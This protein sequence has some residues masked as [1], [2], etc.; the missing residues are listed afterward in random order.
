M[1]ASLSFGLFGL[2][3]MRVL[4]QRCSGLKRLTFLIVRVTALPQRTDLGLKLMPKPKWLC[5]TRRTT[6]NRI[7]FTSRIRTLRSSLR[8]IIRSRGLLLLSLCSVA[9]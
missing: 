8:Y 6:L 2:S 4:V 5:T 7:V 3:S 1:K 9:R